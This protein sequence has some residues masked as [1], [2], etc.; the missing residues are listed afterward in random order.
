MDSR[1]S[2]SKTTEKPLDHHE[3]GQV[4]GACLSFMNSNILQIDNTTEGLRQPQKTV[5]MLK[6]STM[7]LY[8]SLLFILMAIISF[9]YVL[10][11][12]FRRS[13][14]SPFLHYDC[15]DADGPVSGRG[16]HREAGPLHLLTL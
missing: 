13:S 10:A 6:S 1:Y 2:T 8:S 16:K 4:H 9:E 3:H 15:G 11:L 7:A 5:T 14:L 12:L